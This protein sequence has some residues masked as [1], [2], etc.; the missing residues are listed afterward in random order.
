ML[1]SAI[2]LTTANPVIAACTPPQTGTQSVPLLS[3]PHSAVVI[4]NGRL[5]FYSAPTTGCIMPGIFVIPK[6]EIIAYAQSN[7][8]WTSVMYLNPKTGVDVSGWVRSSRLKH[9]GRIAP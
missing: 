1:V 3:P 4:G 8:G 9:K 2:Y 6:D 5:Q 7:D